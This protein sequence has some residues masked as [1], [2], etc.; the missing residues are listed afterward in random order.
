[1][2]EQ[3]P[4]PECDQE[5]FK[6]GQAVCAIDARMW[7]AEEWVKKVRE[8][9][10]Q[11]VDWHYS[12]GRGNVLFLGDYSAVMKAVMELEPELDGQLLTI[13]PPASRGLYRAGDENR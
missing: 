5:V 8:K 10:G 9:S 1:M 12:G 13:F 2:S 7:A 11:R 4:P 6:D 3:I